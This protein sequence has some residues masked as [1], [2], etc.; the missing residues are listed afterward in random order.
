MVDT[1]E[2]SIQEWDRKQQREVCWLE[3]SHVPTPPRE[4][5]ACIS[6][7]SLCKHFICIQG[8]TLARSPARETR[9]VKLDDEILDVGT[10]VFIDGILLLSRA[11]CLMEAGGFMWGLTL[12]SNIITFEWKCLWFAHVC[13]LFF[14][15]EKHSTIV[16]GELTLACFQKQQSLQQWHFSCRFQRPSAFCKSRGISIDVSRWPALRWMPWSF[17]IVILLA[18]R[19]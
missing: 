18:Q 2:A 9:F 14:I 10:V 4:N 13:L 3:M 11:F 17:L 15:R 16:K 19:I 12:S 6:F 8:Q 7:P 1:V 5:I